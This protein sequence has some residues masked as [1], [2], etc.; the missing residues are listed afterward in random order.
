M[1]AEWNKSWRG[2]VQVRKQRAYVREAPLHARG[3][4]LSAHLSKE[5]RQKHKCRSLRLRVGDKVKVMR[6]S[7]RNK[8]GKVDRIN[9][10]EKKVYITGIEFTKRDG[11]KAMYPIHPSNI[12]IEEPDTSDKRRFPETKS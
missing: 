10:K 7:F 4:F 6:G 5:L 12:L 9:A 8:T 3:D 2:S 1:K 11:S